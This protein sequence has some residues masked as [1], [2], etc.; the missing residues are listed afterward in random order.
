[1][2]AVAGAQRV[3]VIALRVGLVLCLLHHNGNLLVILV[4]MEAISTGYECQQQKEN[5]VYGC[6][7]LHELTNVMVS[8]QK[9]RVNDW[10]ICNRVA[11]VIQDLKFEIMIAI[12][13]GHTGEN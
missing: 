4:L 3:T 1:M 10:V 13:K 7:L 11:E 12:C 6:E 2:A 8:N 5:A 9:K